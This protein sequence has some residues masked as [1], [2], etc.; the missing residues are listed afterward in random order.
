MDIASN[1]DHRNDPRKDRISVEA[2]ASDEPSASPEGATSGDCATPGGASPDRNTIVEVDGLERAFGDVQAVDG[3]SFDV[4]SG[5][6]YT[7]VGPNG[8]GKSTTIECI[9]GLQEPD[10]GRVRALGRAPQENRAQFFEKIGV[11]FQEDGLYPDLTV[12]ETLETFAQLY[13][14]PRPVEAMI[15]TFD[16]Q[17]RADAYFKD[18]SGGEKQKVS[19]AVALVGTPELAI[20]DEP[21]SGLDPHARRRLWSTLRS[22]CDDGLTLLLTTHN[23]Q[24]AE[25]HSDVVCMMDEGRIIAEGAPDDLIERYDLE[26]RVAAHAPNGPVDDPFVEEAFSTKALQ[27]LPGLTRTDRMDD[28]LCLYGRGDEFPPAATAYFQKHGVR[29]YAVREAGLEDLYLMI[30]GSQYKTDAS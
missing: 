14:D 6:V 26:M 16:L 23:M 29:E 13:D 22:F 4:G 3:V 18:L 25:A 15:E 11:Q 1:D 5:Q 7:I 27:S 10:A 2:P 12:R 30:T 20:L 9:I 28:T 24:E 21:T 19:I 8:A 17:S